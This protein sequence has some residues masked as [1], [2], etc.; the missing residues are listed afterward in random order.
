MYVLYEAVSSY[1]SAQ[2]NFS[3]MDPVH[4]FFFTLH[5]LILG[6]VWICRKK[7]GPGSC[8]SPFLPSKLPNFYLQKHKIVIFLHDLSAWALATAITRVKTVKKKQV[9]LK[10]ISSRSVTSH[11][12]NL[13]ARYHVEINSFKKRKYNY[14][15]IFFSK[16]LTQSA[17]NCSDYWIVEQLPTTTIT[18]LLA[19]VSKF[20]NCG[21]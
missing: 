12:H 4:L 6:A 15:L 5:I 11:A 13:S 17:A 9:S 3:G 18:F 20:C 14:N 8:R 10:H 7:L 19:I 21:F 2:L 16:P 1:R